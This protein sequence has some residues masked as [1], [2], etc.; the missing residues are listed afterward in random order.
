MEG[1]VSYL[2]GGGLIVAI[3][4]YTVKSFLDSSKDKIKRLNEKDVQDAV[5]DVRLEYEN[6]ITDLKMNILKLEIQ[7]SANEKER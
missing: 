3:I 4:A 1:V 7:L 6:K 5:Q 2:S